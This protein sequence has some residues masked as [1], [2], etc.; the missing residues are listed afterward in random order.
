MNAGTS[1]E[2]ELHLAAPTEGRRG[3][4]LEAL[5]R[6]R[7][8]HRPW[9]YAPLTDAGYDRWLERQAT[10]EFEGFLILRDSD[11][12]LVGMCNLS[13]IV[14]DPLQS[15]YIGFGAI[16][17]YA[18]RGY[19]RAGV[20]LVLGQAFGRLRLHRVEANVQ[21]ANTASKALVRS[22]GFVREGFSER[23]VKVGGRWRD[24]ERWAIR[25]ELW[26]PVARG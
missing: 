1:R 16:E 8:L 23:Y 5:R 15:A 10:E 12:A 17:G 26:R 20:G 21:P 24:H 6:S 19:M 3:Q 4:V 14:R 9:V 11:D 7:R 22:L 2:P 25:K 18:G 13:Q